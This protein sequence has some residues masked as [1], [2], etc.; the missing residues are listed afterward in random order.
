MAT[1]ETIAA[2]YN[3]Q[4]YELAAFLDLESG[5]NL[6]AELTEDQVQEIVE[7]I[8]YDLAHNTPPE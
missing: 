4:P 2:E 3:M 6:N 8:S 7:I 5:R 1:I